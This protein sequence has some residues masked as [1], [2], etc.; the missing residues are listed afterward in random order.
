MNVDCPEAQSYH[1][2]S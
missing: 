2:H 1:P